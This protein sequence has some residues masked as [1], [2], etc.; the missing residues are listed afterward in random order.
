MTFNRSLVIEKP[1]DLEVFLD[2]LDRTRLFFNRFIRLGKV[3][4]GSLSFRKKVETASKILMLSEE[5][6]AWFLAT[7]NTATGVNIRSEWV[8][9]QET[10]I[11][12]RFFWV[13]PSTQKMQKDEREFYFYYRLEAR[14]KKGDKLVLSCAESKVVVP[15]PSTAPQLSK[16]PRRK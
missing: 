3:C 12:I 13:D 2:H 11:V 8:S 6:S 9:K 4:A 14:L 7:L 5:E 15:D 16:K 1:D 10:P